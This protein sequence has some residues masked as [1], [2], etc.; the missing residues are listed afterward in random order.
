MSIGKLLRSGDGRRRW[1]AFVVVV[2][3]LS[4]SRGNSA[5]ADPLR[6]P[7]NSSPSHSG[8][9]HEAGRMWNDRRLRRGRS[10]NHGQHPFPKYVVWL[11]P[12]AG[13]RHIADETFAALVLCQS[14]DFFRIVP[15][16]AKHR[17]AGL[18]KAIANSSSENSSSLTLAGG[19]GSPSW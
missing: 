17:S 13:F 7:F 4:M 16:C 15:F 14:R 6:D 8:H 9:R 1:F 19:R 10:R 18:S 2:A 3:T 12:L 11:N 5:G